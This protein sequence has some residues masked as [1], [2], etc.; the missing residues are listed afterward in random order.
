MGFLREEDKSCKFQYIA[1]LVA[2]IC[3]NLTSIL[4][5]G[6]SS[7]VFAGSMVVMSVNPRKQVGPG[8]EFAM[9]E[10]KHL[11]PNQT[12]TWGEHAGCGVLVVFVSC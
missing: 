7:A 10:G 2:S 3:P 12:S 6:S 11:T 4:G 1:L 5:R 8:P 9:Q